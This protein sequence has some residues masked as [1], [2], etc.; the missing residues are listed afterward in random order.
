ML[1]KLSI[2]MFNKLSLFYQVHRVLSSKMISSLSTCQV[3][4]NAQACVS[5]IHMKKYGR[6]QSGAEDNQV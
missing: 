2:A 5:V 4:K 6:H 1:T 3:G